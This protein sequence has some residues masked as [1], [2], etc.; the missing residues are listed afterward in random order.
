MENEDPVHWEGVL[1]GCEAVL[2]LLGDSPDPV[3][4]RKIAAML[5]A[6][7]KALDELG[8]SLEA[9]GVWDEIVQRFATESLDA[10]P[11]VVF[12]AL[13]H[14]ARDLVDL[15][16]EAAAI[17]TADALVALC[18]SAE[19][20]TD[21]RR[22]LTV[23]ALLTKRRAMQTA[24]GPGDPIHVDDEIIGRFAHDNGPVAHEHVT[25]ALVR[26]SHWLLT[27]DEVDAALTIGRVLTQRMEGAP[28][29]GVL[30]EAERLNQ[31]AWTLIRLGAPNWRGLL[32][33]S[34]F[35]AAN[36]YGEGLRSLRRRLNR[37]GA[38]RPRATTR[39]LDRFRR[40]PARWETWRQRAQASIDVSQSVI[41]RLAGDPDPDAQRIVM[42]AR[43][44][45]AIA[46]SATG[47]V[48]YG[49]G[50]LTRLTR[51]G[52]AA[53]VQA[54]QRL[55]AELR[56]RPDVPGQLGELTMLSQR[57]EAL[58]QDDPRIARIAY[59]DS[60]RPL[61]EGT[62]HRAVRWIARLFRPSRGR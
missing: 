13:M 54:F 57:A 33:V 29:E 61:L 51:T 42:T 21:Q 17:E 28:V 43:I 26:K 5:E 58:G 47:H 25:A 9:V 24:G 3:D 48:G 32:D 6:K 50:E 40:I 19:A 35:F 49:A 45:A 31:Y 56:G 2:A 15:G 39:P 38:D 55:A 7:G 46:H 22:L 37:S 20:E 11:E 36:A 59:D 23:V 8:R 41:E 62:T 27:H 1:A 30:A 10:P 18:D 4:R 14:K 53:A 12:R 44:A 52:D 34:V 16:D 60:I